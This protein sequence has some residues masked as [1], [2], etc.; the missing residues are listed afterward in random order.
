MSISSPA[1]RGSVAI[2]TG[3]V[4]IP[5]IAMMGL[6][7]DLARVWL[8][9]S[10]L[11]MSLDAAVLVAARDLGTGGTSGSEYLDRAAERHRVFSDLSALSSFFIPRSKLPALPPEVRQRMG[12]RFQAG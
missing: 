10:G 11:Q 12:F 8:V 2:M 9:K 5:L 4:A 6:A 1:R 3:L 7:V